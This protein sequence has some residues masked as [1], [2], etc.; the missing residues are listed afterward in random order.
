MKKSNLTTALNI[1]GVVVG[2][3]ALAYASVPLYDLFC[4]VTGFAGTTQTSAAIPDKIYDRE[5]TVLFNTDVNPE[6]PWEFKP[7]QSKVKVKVGE[8]KLVFFEAKN[9]SDKPVEGIASYNVV[10]E[11]FG[12]YFNK[13]QC[14]CF[15]RQVLKPGEKMN[16]PVSFF[17]DP[18]MMKDN[19]LNGKNDVTLS[20][21][22]FP[23]KK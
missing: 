16:F 22:F 3:F 7:L 8:N 15:E 4:K 18:E 11:A 9:I 6:L 1:I 10:P 19:E 20:Y 17:I 21:T 2:M 23:Y 12:A 5:I 14:F 13:L